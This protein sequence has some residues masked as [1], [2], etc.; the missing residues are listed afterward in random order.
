MCLHALSYAASLLKFV[1]CKSEGELHQRLFW[2]AGSS[3]GLR[4]LH[5]KFE[6]LITKPAFGSL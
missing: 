6:M 5:H 4:Q 3:L 1:L 2:H